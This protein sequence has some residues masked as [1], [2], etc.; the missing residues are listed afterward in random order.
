MNST[1]SAD[2]SSA[3]SKER[4]K[5]LITNT[6]PREKHHLQ[7]ISTKQRPLA[8]TDNNSQPNLEIKKSTSS[9]NIMHSI[10]SANLCPQGSA[11]Q[12]KARAAVCAGAKMEGETE[13]EGASRLRLL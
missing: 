10:I 6:N 9:F 5:G 1:E 12:K 3:I 4:R 13:A 7:I 2:F 11:A 8:Q